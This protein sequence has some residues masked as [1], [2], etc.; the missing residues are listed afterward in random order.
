MPY[1]FLKDRLNEVNH[2]S[3]MGMIGN[4]NLCMRKPNFKPTV[5]FEEEV[6]GNTANRKVIWVKLHLQPYFS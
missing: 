1:I 3:H 4:G 5:N 2:N 6:D